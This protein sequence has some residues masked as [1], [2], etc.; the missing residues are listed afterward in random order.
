MLCGGAVL[1]VVSLATGEHFAWPPTP[2]AAAA[3]VYLVV[4]GSLIGFSAYLY[5]LAHAAPALA[6]SYAFVNPVIALL[7]GVGLAG[8]VV[9]GAEWA[10]SG[11]V[12]FGVVLILVAARKPRTDT[13]SG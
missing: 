2:Q 8:E 9:T 11:V 4:F 5:L 1:M 7:L 10:A 12:L 13:R 6:T 3:W